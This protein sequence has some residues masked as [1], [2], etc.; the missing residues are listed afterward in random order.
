[1]EF[2][3]TMAKKQ[4]EIVILTE[5]VK[6]MTKQTVVHEK[7]IFSLNEEI[8]DFTEKLGNM[9][10]EEIVQVVERLNVLEEKTVKK[11]EK[12]K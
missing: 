11:K 7:K 10:K 4:S 9:G 1:M 12:I 5:E 3:L 2:P 6:K 8:K